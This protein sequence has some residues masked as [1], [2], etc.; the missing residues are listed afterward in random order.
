[1]PPKSIKRKRDEK[2]EGGEKSATK[3]PKKSA[4][5]NGTPAE[6]PTKWLFKSEPESR[7]EKGVDM[8]FGFSDLKAEKD[9]VACWDGVRNYQARN[10]MRNMKVGEE[11]FFYHSNTKIPGIIGLVTIVREAYPDHTQFDPKDPHYDPK[12]DKA[13]PRWDMVDVKYNRELKRYIPLPELKSLHQAHKSSGGPLRN[14][15]LFTSARL[16]VQP[17]TEEEWNFILQLEN[18]KK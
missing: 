8:K 13:S 14:L 1:M 18:E 16:S 15:A 2:V 11:G 10:F 17:V 6:K 5:E 4:N 12:S 7:M 9:G 3:Q